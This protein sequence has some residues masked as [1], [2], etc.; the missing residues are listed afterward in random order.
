[1]EKQKKL[2]NYQPNILYPMEISFKDKIKCFKEKKIERMYCQHV[3][4]TRNVK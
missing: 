1:M 3:C 2:S 4:T